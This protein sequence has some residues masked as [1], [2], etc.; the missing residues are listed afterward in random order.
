MMLQPDCHDDSAQQQHVCR[1]LILIKKPHETIMKPLRGFWDE[2]K[3]IEVQ[4]WLYLVN[5]LGWRRGF[6][7]ECLDFGA[8]VN[9]DLIA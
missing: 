6:L 3:L 8:P 1:D 7:C 2:T 4:F 9:D 5:V